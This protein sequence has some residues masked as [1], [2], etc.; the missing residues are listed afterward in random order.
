MNIV[1]FIIIGFILG[2][3]ALYLMQMKDLDR[4]DEAE[5]EL[6]K[7]RRALV[8]AEAD[9]EARLKQ[10]IAELQTNYQQKRELEVQSL[11]LDFNEKIQL[12]KAKLRK[13]APTEEIPKLDFAIPKSSSQSLTLDPPKLAADIQSL[14][15]PPELK[16][17]IP[18]GKKIDPPIM[19]QSLQTDNAAIAT[20]TQDE[21]EPPILAAEVIYSSNPSEQTVSEPSGKQIDPPIQAQ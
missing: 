12:L 17:S 5:F 7:S 13:V 1:I 4:L 14:E 8:D 15:E 21:S 2:A 3:A 11:T 6:K 18:T 20:P 10:A 16:I 9:H 19:A